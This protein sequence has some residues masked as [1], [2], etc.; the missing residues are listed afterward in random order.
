MC[1]AGIRRRPVD[2]R[3]KF[4]IQWIAYVVD[5]KTTVTRRSIAILAADDHMVQ[6]NAFALRQVVRLARRAVHARKPPL[7]DNFRFRDVLQ[8]NDS[9]NM[10]GESLKVRRQ[11]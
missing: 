11:I 5:R 10:I 6:R 9:E 2:A 3:K 1:A 8:I 7:G 4:W